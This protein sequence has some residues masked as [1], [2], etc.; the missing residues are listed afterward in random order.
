MPRFVALRYMGRDGCTIGTNGT[1]NRLPGK[2]LV[3]AWP[4]LEQFNRSIRYSL[5]ISVECRGLDINLYMP[6]ASTIEQT[7][8]AVE[9]EI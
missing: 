7:I 4:Y 2:W 1:Y 3:A 5:V 9:T 8:P 6:I